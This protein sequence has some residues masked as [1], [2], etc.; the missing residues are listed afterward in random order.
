MSKSNNEHALRVKVSKWL[1]EEMM[2]S[3]LWFT[4]V[5]PGQFMRVGTPDYLICKQ[6]RFVAIELKLDSTDLEP[7]QVVEMNKIRAVDGICSVCRSL[8]E[9]KAVLEWS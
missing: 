8:E 9:V 2:A 7:R 5:T 4:K 6:G 1:A 3:R